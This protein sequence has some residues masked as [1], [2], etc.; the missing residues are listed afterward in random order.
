MLIFV[1]LRRAILHEQDSY[2]N[3]AR[4]PFIVATLLQS[5]LNVAPDKSNHRL[6]IDPGSRTTG[7][8]IVNDDTGEIEFAAELR[9]RGQQIKSSLDKRRA[10]RRGRRNRKT[11]YR[12]PRF[13]N[14]TRP[15]GWLAPSLLSRAYNIETWVNRLRRLCPINAISMELVCFD[16]QAMENPEINGVEYQQGELWGYEVKEY[17][18]EKF[19]RKCAYCDVENIPLQ[20]E[21][22]VPKM[23]GGS[24]RVNNL[25]IACQ[26][27][28]QKKGK[29]TAA[30]FGFPQIQTKAKQPLK[31]AASV[32]TTRWAIYRHLQ[33]TRL[34]IEV[35]TGGQTK[36]NRIQRGLPKTHWLD[37]VCVG[38]STPQILKVKGVLPLLITATGHGSRQMCR[39]DKYGFPRTRAKTQ[40]RV[41]G[42]QTGDLVKA[43]VTKGKKAG[44]YVGRVAVRASGSFNITAGKG[45]AQGISYRYCK[46]LHQSDGYNYA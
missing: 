31:D 35:G 41:K 7:I 29:Q 8:A 14:R 11:R 27:C 45:T 46:Q 44:V 20:V 25:T 22:I 21:H 3:V 16:M 42:F 19:N 17:L 36:F 37:A 39:V 34:P 40:R 30:E 26:S 23:R 5:F 15:N 13:N 32:N 12:K 10:I 4:L 24:N 6:K 28:N 38:E 9:H 18:L 33:L 43:V 1:H 2:L